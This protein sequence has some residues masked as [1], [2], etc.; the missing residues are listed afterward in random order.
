MYFLNYNR[1]SVSDCRVRR[2]WLARFQPDR[3]QLPLP[4]RSSR[5][6]LKWPHVGGKVLL[7]LL[8]LVTVVCLL[9][10]D[11]QQRCTVVSLSLVV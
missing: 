4:P 10:I 1:W 6:L 9:N 7:L 8:L 3:Q 11:Q 5:S 2:S